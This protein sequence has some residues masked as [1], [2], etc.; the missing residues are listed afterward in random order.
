MSIVIKP[1]G[2]RIVV[3]PLIVQPT[4]PENVEDGQ[5]H[6]SLDVG[7]VIAI[8]PRAKTQL[9]KEHTLRIGDSVVYDSYVASRLIVD[10]KEFHIIRTRF[11][12]AIIN[13][14]KSAKEK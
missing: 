5:A 9:E 10:G 7:K 1:I 12:E 8:G 3:E 14:S 6:V 4:M 2:D 11:V 13:R